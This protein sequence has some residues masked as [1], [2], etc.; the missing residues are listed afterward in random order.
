[1]SDLNQFHA[2]LELQHI[3]LEAY[4]ERFHYLR[5]FFE[6]I[7]VIGTNWLPDRERLTGNRFSIMAFV[8]KQPAR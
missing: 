2:Q 4:A 3:Y 7:I 1:M 8:Q 6:G 5:P